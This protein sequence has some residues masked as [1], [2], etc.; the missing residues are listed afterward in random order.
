MDFGLLIAIILSLRI[1][2]QEDKNWRYN[3]RQVIIST[4]VYEVM[5]PDVLDLA[6]NILKFTESS[7]LAVFHLNADQN[8]SMDD[9]SQLLAL[10]ERRIHINSERFSVR[11][12]TFDICRAFLSNAVYIRSMLPKESD[13]IVV[14]QDS[15]M[16][17]IRPCLEIYLRATHCTRFLPPKRSSLQLTQAIHKQYAGNGA[18]RNFL[19]GNKSTLIHHDHEG[20]FYLLSTLIDLDAG[21]RRLGGYNRKL[22]YGRWPE[23]WV[24]STFAATRQQQFYDEC[25]G[26]RVCPFNKAGNGIKFTQLNINDF[27]V[28]RV[29]RTAEINAS[30]I[31]LLTDGRIGNNARKIN[32]KAALI[33]R[34]KMVNLKPPPAPNASQLCASLSSS[35]YLLKYDQFHLNDT[36]YTQYVYAQNKNDLSTIQQSRARWKAH[37]LQ[38]L[39][40]RERAL[41]LRMEKL[42]PVV[43]ER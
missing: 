39:S 7:T 17:W 32:A 30:H 41:G 10:G 3:D 5:N 37:Q 23:Q 40:K 33:F 2:A 8:Y 21:L 1:R 13:P 27:S 42:I 11:W 4:L 12:G 18:I 16:Y 25:L 43:F 20:T 6:R 29:F 36:Y 28:K 38:I 19:T 35:I 26:A 24:F 9:K 14:W 15:N 22:S 34:T 31:G